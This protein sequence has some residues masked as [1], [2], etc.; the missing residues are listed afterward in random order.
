VEPPLLVE[1]TQIPAVEPAVVAGEWKDAVR[2]EIT[3]GDR[4]TGKFD[5]ADFSGPP[6][7]SIPGDAHEHARERESHAHDVLHVLRVTWN[8]LRAVCLL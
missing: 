5:G 7:R 6:R 8:R 3:A 4:R 1:V 2:R